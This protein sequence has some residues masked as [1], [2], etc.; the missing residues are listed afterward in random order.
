MEEY[1]NADK[2]VDYLFELMQENNTPEILSRLTELEKIYSL[3]SGLSGAHI[4]ELGG[5]LL[6]RGL[7]GKAIEVYENN[8]IKCPTDSNVFDS[9]GEACRRAAN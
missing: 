9:L 5:R 1:Y 8:A 6:D 7:I 2:L 3:V 4:N